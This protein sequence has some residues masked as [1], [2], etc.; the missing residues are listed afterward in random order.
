MNSKGFR[1]K[2]ESVDF[3]LCFAHLYFLIFFSYSEYVL[4]LIIKKVICN[5]KSG[6]FSFLAS[7]WTVSFWR[8]YC[9]EEEVPD[10]SQCALR[11]EHSAGDQ[12]GSIL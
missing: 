8:G 6:L 3:G 4:C 10:Y 5:F 2:C 7:Y 11:T 9:G 12:R 1:L